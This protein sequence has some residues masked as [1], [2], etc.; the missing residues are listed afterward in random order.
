VQEIDAHSINLRVAEAGLTGRRIAPLEIGGTRVWLKDFDQPSPPEWESVQRVLAT[1]F[2]LQILRPVPAL[3][4]IEGARNE[5]TAMQAFRESGVR[6]PELLWAE[7][8]RLLI[9]DIGPTIR[10]E[11]HR[12]ARVTKACLAAAREL[13]RAHIRDL[14][15]GR[16]ILRNMSWDGA[17]VGF[18]DFEERPTN[19]MPLDVAQARDVSLYLIS[20]GRH[21]D[22]DFLH[23]AFATYAEN[24][25][26]GVDRELQRV[27]RRSAM[28]LETPFS[29]VTAARSR[30]LRSVVL[31]LQAVAQGFKRR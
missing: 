28:F 21:F 17:S 27:V 5:V 1:V 13:A 18:I 22:G 24:S 14:V 15:H 26:P 12:S 16:P 20:L 4:G 7:G 30:T 19:V 31:A 2:F 11:K 6:V 25:K 10:E 3:G 29:K 9:S 23:K 8:A